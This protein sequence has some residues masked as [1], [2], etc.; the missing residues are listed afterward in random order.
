MHT[1]YNMAPYS[2]FRAKMSKHEVSRQKHDILQ[3][4]KK[5]S[6]EMQLER[7]MAASISKHIQV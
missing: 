3:L 2:C 5:Y 4:N 7:N 6:N 1:I